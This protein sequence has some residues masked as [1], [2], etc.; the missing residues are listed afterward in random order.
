M[1]DKFVQAQLS[2]MLMGAVARIKANHKELSRLDSFGGDGDHGSAMLRAADAIAKTVS[3]AKKKATKDLLSDTAWAVMGI[4]GGA[5]GPLLGSF[6]LG[7]SDAAGKGKSLDAKGLSALFIS[8]LE[9]VMKNTPARAGDKTMLDALIP[10]VEAMQTGAK[11]GAG[12]PDCLKSA[13]DA[14]AK[15]AETTSKMKARFGR[16]KNLGDKSIGNKDAGAVSMSLIFKGFSEGV[17]SA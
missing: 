13:A 5:T 4:D 8:G 17:E 6:F 3:G 16:A 11:A 14:A 10:A 7:M 2:A 1:P 15:G 12:I 9:G